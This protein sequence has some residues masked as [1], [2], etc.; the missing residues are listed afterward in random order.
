M[1]SLQREIFKK[2]KKI[3]DQQAVIDS[4]DRQQNM[5]AAEAEQRVIKVQDELKKIMSKC[6]RSK[7]PQQ[8]DATI[9]EY[10]SAG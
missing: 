1:E 7:I 5:K 9:T 2:D 6:R 10:E 4:S 8:Q 3:K